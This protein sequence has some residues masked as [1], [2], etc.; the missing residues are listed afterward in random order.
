MIL[1][2]LLISL[3]NNVFS[4]SFEIEFF[5][6]FESLNIESN[7]SPGS[8]NFLSNSLCL[9][10]VFVCF[11]NNF[12]ESKQHDSLNPNKHNEKELSAKLKEISKEIE[13]F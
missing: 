4:C 12:L 11:I 13:I 9:F 2:I 5:L 8:S 7:N 3:T 10:C 1:I 6:N